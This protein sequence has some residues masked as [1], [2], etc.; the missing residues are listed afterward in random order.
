MNEFL[1]NYRS[2]LIYGA[3]VI[4]AVIILRYLT[5]WLHGM[6]VRKIQAKFPHQ[7]TRSLELIRVI[8]SALWIV[9]GVIALSFIF[10]DEESYAQVSK[11]FRLVLYVGVVAVLT[12]VAAALTNLWFRRNIDQKLLQGS[13]PTNLKFLRYVAI[14][15]CYSVG[16]L[17]ATLAFPALRGIAQTVLGGAGV[18]ALIAGV[19]SQEALANLVGGVFIISFKPFKI[20]D[21]IEISSAM[22]GTVVDINLRHTVI[23]NFD[24]KMIVIPNSIINKEKLINYDLN[25]ARCC[26]RIEI[27]I[28]YDSDVKLAKE[29][30]RQECEQ[31]PNCIDKRTGVDLQNDKPKVRTAL[32]RYN[33]SSVTIRAWAWAN[34]FDDAFDL[35]CDVLESVKAR[36]ER[37]GVE[38]PFPYRTVVFKRDETAEAD[39]TD[40]QK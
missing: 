39:P 23:R 13:D 1:A 22:V 31:H 33:D 10:I 5:R 24:N 2:H 8:F 9:L 26:E 38:L 21:V 19:A 11:D 12:V 27:G 7:S 35:R 14:I 37:E 4:L 25:D 36:Y 29:I 16:I 32:M 18:L 3:I 30:L 17:F 15:A 34:N 28:S 6:L 40:P 20:G